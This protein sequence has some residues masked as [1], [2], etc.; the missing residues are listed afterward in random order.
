MAWRRWQDLATIVLGIVA[1]ASPF[2]YGVALDSSIAMAA[3]AAGVLLVLS[4]L[5]TVSAEKPAASFEWIPVIVG[6][7]LF[8]APWALSYTATTEM[9]WTSWI[10]GL[11]AVV[12]GIG[13]MVVL[14]RSA[15]QPV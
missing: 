10:V 4:G 2:V 12:N 8:V 1:F 9:A 11:L 15:A 6:A 13:E 3:Y 14:T 5:W 7:A